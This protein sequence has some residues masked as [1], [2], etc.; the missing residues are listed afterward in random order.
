MTDT[1]RSN[2]GDQEQL[3]ERHPHHDDP[4][5][6]DVERVSNASTISNGGLGGG[7]EEA[8]KPADDPSERQKI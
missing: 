2:A 4:T 5:R 8:D 7:R 1:S 6:N 3:V